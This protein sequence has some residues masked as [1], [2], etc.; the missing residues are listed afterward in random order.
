[1]A[2]IKTEQEPSIE[3][4]LESIRQIIS[5]DGTPVAEGQ[6]NQAA[7]PAPE[8]VL[9][10]QPAPAKP[11]AETVLKGQ[12]APAKTAAQSL[13]Q[14]QQQPKPAPSD[15]TLRGPA[16]EPPQKPFATAPQPQPQESVLE[17]TD[18]VDPPEPEIAA[19]AE[20][21]KARIVLEESMEDDDPLMSDMTAE[22]AVSAM[23][24]IMAQNIAVE[25]EMPGRPGNVTLEDMAKE[26]M[27]PLIKVW[28]DKNLPVIIEKLVAREI[29]KLARRALDKE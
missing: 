5:D 3:E 4:I 7:K 19:P 10:G 8:T 16:P 22:K 14:Q 1:M 9:K 27:H 18:K 15:L 17:L 2:E 11:A 21:P 29:E 13:S 20:Q 28:L 12:P 25:R 6:Q 23:A 26:L 24:R